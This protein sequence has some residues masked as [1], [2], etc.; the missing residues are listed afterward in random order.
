MQYLVIG[1]LA[2]VLGLVV[3]FAGTTLLSPSDVKPIA[4]GLITVGVVAMGIGG[5]E[6]SGARRDKR[7]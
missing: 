4:T 3:G 2:L 1:I 7:S 6:R 5:L